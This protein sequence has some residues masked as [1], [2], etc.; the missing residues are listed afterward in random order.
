MPRLFWVVAQSSGT[1]QIVLGHS[2]LERRT[3]AGLFLQRLAISGNRLFELCS[4]AL[5]LSETQKR[6]AQIVLGHGPVERA[7]RARSQPQRS[8]IACNG[9]R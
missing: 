7:L 9:L 3:L 8:S 2:P 1:L 4:L 5:P 6:I